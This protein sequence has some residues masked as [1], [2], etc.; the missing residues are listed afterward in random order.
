VIWPWNE[1][2][3]DHRALPRWHHWLLATV[4]IAITMLLTPIF[5]AFI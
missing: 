3:G 5:A 4:L 2:R 1:G